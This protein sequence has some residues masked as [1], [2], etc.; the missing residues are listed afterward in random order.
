MVFLASVAPMMYID[1][2]IDYIQYTYTIIYNTHIYIYIHIYI[3]YTYN[4]Y[5]YYNYFSIGL[6]RSVSM[7]IGLA[8]HSMPSM[9]HFSHHVVRRCR[10]ERYAWCP[11]LPPPPPPSMLGRRRLR[12]LDHSE[13][14]V[15]IG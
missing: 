6:Y 4:I 7:W 13:L 12:N 9:P 8:D 2:Y 11:S 10:K 5:I 14:T 15:R 1:V 3:I